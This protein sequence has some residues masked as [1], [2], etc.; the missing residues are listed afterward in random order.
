VTAF[1]LPR[2]AARLRAVARDGHCNDQAGVGAHLI[3]YS[4]KDGA[5]FAAQLRRDLEAEGFTIWQDLVALE[6]GR[7]WWS[8]IEAAL[9]SK[10]L[11]HFIL[12]VTPQAPAS[13]IVRREIR[14]ARQEGKTFLPV[15]GPGLGDLG[16]LPR[17][18]GQLT[19][20]DI[21]EHRT[22]LRRILEAPSSVRRVPMMAPEP[23][24]DFVPRP[25]EFEAL[26]RQLLDA[27]G[28]AVGITAARR[29]RLRQDHARQGAGP[30]PRHPGRL[31]R[32]RLGLSWASRA[33]ARPTVINGLV[34]LHRHVAQTTTLEA[35][36]T[37]LAEALGDLRILPGSCPKRR[38]ASRWMRCSRA[39]RWRCSRG[40]CPRTKPGGAGGSWADSP[41]GSTSGRSS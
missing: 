41:P 10:A 3:S 8:Q 34:A 11:Q 37:A 4:R 18:I 35:A 13:P 40:V 38:S 39:R 15:R 28:D 6:G 24:A 22:T 14:L 25:R 32:R 7:D 33:A 29:G 5:G 36:R 26:K 27:K 16:R 12:A 21:A 9:K 20:L 23:P 17:W 1:A 2:S 19:D 31:F 30:R